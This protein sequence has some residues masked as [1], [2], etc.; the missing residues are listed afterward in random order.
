MTDTGLDRLDVDTPDGRLVLVNRYLNAI[1]DPAAAAPSITLAAI[2]AELGVDYD[3]ARAAIAKHGW[4]NRG[5]M[6][7]AAQALRNTVRQ[8]PREPTSELPHHQPSRGRPRRD[9]TPA[10]HRPTAPERPA[11]P[12]QP[13]PSPATLP[14]LI[15]QGRAHKLKRIRDLAEKAHTAAKRLDDALSAD[16]ARAMQERERQ[17]AAAR[18][19]AH[20]ANLEKQL[21][22]A[23][24][25]L[26]GDTNRIIRAWAKGEGIP[27]G[28]AG[29][30][31]LRVLEAYAKA[32][33]QQ[34]AAR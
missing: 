24:A 20:A 5:A 33:P 27:T 14:D 19:V 1:G 32:H 11:M 25:A 16:L 10:Q 22:K 13:A 15:S 26:S 17:A 21:E 31:P 23:R 8:T 4:P 34:Q 28:A 2:A 6:E 12:Q 3:E 29:R 9:G 7:R 30:L 18:A